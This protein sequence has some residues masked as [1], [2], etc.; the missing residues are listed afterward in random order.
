MDTSTDTRHP[1]G[2]DAAHGTLAATGDGADQTAVAHRL[3]ARDL[4]TQLLPVGQDGAFARPLAERY[5]SAA[6]VVRAV[7]EAVTD[8]LAAA[9]R[10]RPLA[11]GARFAA[12]RGL[13]QPVVQGPMTRVSDRAAFAKSVA[14]GGGL[15]FLALALMTG[16]ESRELL[17]ETAALLG[18][19]PWGVGILG[20]APPE[21][22]EAQLA[23]VREVGPPCALIAGGRPSQSAPLEAVGIDTF[24]HVPSPGLLE[25]FLTDGAR[26]F[27][28]EGRECGGHVGPRASFPLWEAQIAGLLAYGDTLS[29][30][31]AAEFF[32]GLHLLFA[33]GVH[34]ERSA[35]AVAAAAAPLAERGAGIGVLMGTAYLFTEESV[36]S[37]AIMPGFQAAAVGCEETVLLETS[38]GHATRC[39][40]SPYVRAFL[41]TKRQLAASGAAR[42]QMWEELERL[43]LGRLRIASKGL[44]RSGDAVIEVDTETQARDG[45]FMI[46]QVAGLRSAVTTVADLHA[47]V[48]DG[49]TAALA[50]R[51][52]ALGVTTRPAAS[53]REPARPLDIAIVG[54][55]AVFPDAPDVSAFWANIVGGVDAVTEVPTSRWDPA[56]YY[57]PTAVLKNSSK[58]VPSKWGGFLPAV[59]FDALAYG[60]PPKSLTSIE[61]GQLLA[62]EVT[63]RALAD[64]GYEVPGPT[65]V[66]RGGAGR[67]GR[68]EQQGRRPFDRARTS[69]VFGAES[70]AD[71]SAA[72]G[73]RSAWE[74]YFETIPP[75]LD[76]HLPVMDEDSFPGL[77]AN[78]I[79][80]RIANRLDLGGV[81][82]TLDAACASS[83]AAL[84]AACK[85]LSAGTSEMVLCGGVDTHNG[86]HDFLLFSSLHALS[87]TGRSRSFD[88]AADGICLGEGV[89]V[90]VLKRLADA[91]RDGDRIHAVIDAVAGSS[92]G[93]ALGMTAPRQAGQVLSLERAYARAGISPADVG[94]IEA[95]ATGT[96]VGDRTELTS[97]T[98]VFVESGAE[99]GSCAVGSVKSQIGH[100]KCAAGL[101][102]LIKAAKALE[103]GIRP[104]TL[105]VTRPNDY[106]DQSTSP[107]FFDDAARPWVAPPSERHAGLS[108]FGFGGTN[109]HAVLSAYDGA[110]EPAH[111]LDQWPAELFLFRGTDRAAAG[112]R[113]D[114]LAELLRVGDAAGRPWRLRDLAR[115]ISEEGRGT[116]QVAVV[117]DDLDALVVVLERA[118]RFEHA[119]K[120]GIFVADGALT[121]PA[122]PAAPGG[123]PVAPP[124]A[125]LFPGQGSQRPNMLADLFVAFPRLRSLLMAGAPWARTMF[126]PTAFTREEAAAQV[127]AI[128]D[129]RVAQPTLGIAGLAAHTV[130]SSLG[131]RPAMAAGHSY[132]ELVALA[133][134][135][136]LDPAQLPGLSAARADAI[137]GAAGDDPGT[138]AAVSATVEQITAALGADSGVIVANHN[139]PRQ[140]VIS[141]PTPSVER[142]VATLAAAGLVAKRIPVAAAFH[143][144]VVAGAAETFAE[145]V[146]ASTVATPSVPVWSNTTARPY[147]AAP[148]GIRA[149]LARQVAEP[150]RF[151]DQ[152]EDMYAA[153][154]R[155]FIEVGPGRVLTGLTGKILK[156][157]PH[158][159]VALDVPGESGV[160]RLLLAVAELATVGVAVDV[161]PLFAGRDARLVAATPAPRAPGWLIDGAIVRSADGRPL[162]GGL[163]PLDGLPRLASPVAPAVPVG[164]DAFAPAGAAG[165]DATVLEFLRTTRER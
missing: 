79:A 95:H 157:V 22:R 15:P 48:T 126:P 69:V 62:L 145:A 116:V 80:G 87:P 3:G 141:G 102:G 78:V 138:M 119:P 61:P 108:A 159:A 85:E 9:A 2:V 97:L 98:E 17:V 14:D 101:A 88:S 148:D 113:M 77:L 127:A 11:S 131:V 58:R 160:R 94:L 90:V 46:G 37:G 26:K 109:F 120:A 86:V 152:I 35:A 162:P 10:A 54:M 75:E 83:L 52:A 105:N 112:R 4:R 6:G 114:K 66:G 29:E 133:A 129:T 103:T 7:R 155:V 8:H 36:S 142:A 99:P 24:L 91:E 147:P 107:F 34:D 39:V 5:V 111:G 121:G 137:L 67:G 93:R 144:E 18:D 47:Q 32:S 151:V 132:G 153:G 124:V 74:S 20:F 73:F 130:L 92:D 140:A 23:A 117:A 96:V 149:S 13:A 71:L 49:A 33:G 161:A 135:G 154:A 19:A 100:T 55:A 106:W 50:D 82:F 158:R 27:V 115:T 146:A 1:G 21:L 42:Q 12:T 143:S 16:A 40:D 41:E 122:A 89:A 156:D 81:N 38:P 139:A 53:V 59:P 118:R 163:Q 70:G 43:N 65:G 72:Y 60:I 165:A 64:A 76:A 44:R 104:P 57:D 136:A 68:P 150:V 128:T 31:A 84:D 45:M 30:A 110:P 28:F 63:A 25:R 56:V 134:T 51:A 125:F 164:V 123:A